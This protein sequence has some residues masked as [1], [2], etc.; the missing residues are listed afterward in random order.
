MSF[1]RLP[2]SPPFGPENSDVSALDLNANSSSSSESD[3]TKDGP[4]EPAP[5]PLK[6]APARKVSKDKMNGFLKE[7][8]DLEKKL[9]ALEVE[10]CSL[11]PVLPI[12]LIRQI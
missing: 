6:P 4:P 5:V 3:S 10:S 2:P 7:L 8:A 1:E 9:E 11:Q 12:I